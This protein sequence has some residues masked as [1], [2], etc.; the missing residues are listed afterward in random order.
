[1][2]FQRTFSGAPWESQVGYCRALRAGDRV[3]VTGTAPVAEGGG[4][5]APGDAYAQARRC[6]EIMERALRDVGAELSDVTRTRM[7][8]TD[9]ERWAEF[10]RAHAEAFGAHPP[11]TTMVEV[12]RLIDPAML[13]EIEADAV[14][15]RLSG[16]Y[17]HSMVAGG[18]ELTSYVTR[19]TPSTS[20]MIRVEMRPRTSWGNGYQSAVIP[21]RDVTARRASTLS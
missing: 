1:M 5:H 2:P 4:V 14:V 16:S 3:F 7:F 11:T 15:E 19:L 6:F 10:G 17:S 12:R 9:I 21:S 13:I 18:F 20:L 8:V